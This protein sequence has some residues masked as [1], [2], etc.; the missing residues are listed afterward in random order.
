MPRRRR[1]PARSFFQRH[2]SINQTN[3]PGRAVCSSGTVYAAGRLA[4]RQSRNAAGPAGLP[5]RK[6]SAG[7]GPCAAAVGTVPTNTCLVV[8]RLAYG[9]FC[10]STI[11]GRRFDSQPAG[12]RGCSAPGARYPQAIEQAG[13]QCWRAGR[14]KGGKAGLAGRAGDMH[15]AESGSGRGHAGNL[16]VELSRISGQSTRRGWAAR[17]TQTCT[18]TNTYTRTVQQ[19]AVLDCL[20]RSPACRQAAWNEL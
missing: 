12:Q 14:W 3:R 4:G 8:G 9:L 6:A 16:P 7:L 11:K 10:P 19:Q 15:A 1:S 13:R 18:H 17:S 20:G 5:T 2:P